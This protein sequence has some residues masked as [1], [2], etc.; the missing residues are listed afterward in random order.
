MNDSQTQAMKFFYP[1]SFDYHRG[2]GG[3]DRLFSP[4]IPSRIGS[5]LT[6]AISKGIRDLDP[7]RLKA[8]IEMLSNSHTK[9]L[10]QAGRGEDVVCFPT[11]QAAEGAIL[12]QNVLADLTKAENSV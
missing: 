5:Q 3:Y 11:E 9:Y 6:D 10:S 12:L 1:V 8:A 4:A 7:D 2:W